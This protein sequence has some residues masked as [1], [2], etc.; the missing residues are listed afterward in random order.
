M[1]IETMGVIGSGT[2]GAGITQI[3]AQSGLRVTLVDVSMDQLRR[4]LATISGGLERRVA[5][6]Q[7][8]DDQKSETL[9]RIRT[10][11]EMDAVADADL[12][13]E[14]VPE[15]IEMKKSVFRQLDA[16]CSPKTL[17][18]SNTSSLSIS[19]I[20][21]ATKRPA[22]VVGMH[23][24]NPVAAMQLVEIV[25]GLATADATVDAATDLAKRLGKT[26]ITINDSPGFAVNR[27]LVPMINEA[28]FALMEGVA[29]AQDIDQAT[30]LGMN[31]PMGPLELADLIGLD[32]CL[33]VMESLYADFGDSKYRPCPL[34]R[35]MVAANRLGRKNGIGF[36]EYR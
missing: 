27:V 12:V 33:A 36:Y 16:V 24:F 4:A 8:T 23:F 10:A 18:A 3:A 26:P 31:L 14:A 17:L 20:A 34:L 21:A 6:G 29:T 35:K 1:D 15:Q 13:I 5:R 25:K 28:V 22:Q 7:L 11:V 2:M 30:K 19:L 32:V 9:G